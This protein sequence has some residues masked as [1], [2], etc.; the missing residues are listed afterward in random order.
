M[1][2]RDPS[3]QPKPPAQPVYG[4]EL[5]SYRNYDE[6]REYFEYHLI[7]G[8]KKFPRAFQPIK[9]LTTDGAEC[10]RIT[11]DMLLSIMDK[12]FDDKDKKLA[13]KVSTVFEN[14][15]AQAGEIFETIRSE[16]SKL[17]ESVRHSLRIYGW[18][19][20]NSIKIILESLEVLEKLLVKIKP[21]EAI[22]GRP[23]N[24]KKVQLILDVK[25]ALEHTFTIKFPKTFEYGKASNVEGRAFSSPQLEFLLFLV[26]TIDDTIK[27][28]QIES[29]LRSK[30]EVEK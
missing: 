9:T 12:Y 5:F 30:T 27:R 8:E 18:D 11:T 6:W 25:T 7:E 4:G 28:S 10:N 14:E 21:V 19:K 23:D 16:I 3:S 13:T 26:K 17:P 15:K 22:K 29:A 1:N 24:K 20:P 2:S